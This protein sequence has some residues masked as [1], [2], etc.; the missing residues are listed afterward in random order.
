LLGYK[1]VAVICI[2]VPAQYIFGWKIIQYKK[3]N[4]PNNRE[5]A[6]IV[7]EILP[8][9]KLV[10]F[11][12]WESYFE[13]LIGEVNAPDKKYLPC[14][15]ALQYCLQ[16]LFSW[17][18]MTHRL[19]HW[20]TLLVTN[21]VAFRACQLDLCMPGCMLAHTYLYVCLLKYLTSSSTAQN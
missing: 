10:K 6:I 4:G 8:A 12:A 11:Y 7:K 14:L 5:R 16:V 9:M 18:S 1:G 3:L 17:P 2:I 15:W 20:F 13:K 21:S 19:A